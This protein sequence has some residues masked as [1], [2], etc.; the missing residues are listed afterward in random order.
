M[1]YDLY[2][3]QHH[4]NPGTLS[5]Y[6]VTNDFWRRSGLTAEQCLHY[7]T[8]LRVRGIICLGGMSRWSGRHLAEK[9][10]ESLWIASFRNRV[11]S[12]ILLLLPFTI[13]IL[14]VRWLFM[15]VFHLIHP[16][17]IAVLEEVGRIPQIGAIPPLITSFL[18]TI[19]SI[20]LLAFVL[21]LVGSI[22]RW[23]LIRRI[24]DTG[25]AII[26]K[27][28]MVRTIYSAI[29][30]GIQV[31][32]LPEGDSFKR[33]VL[34]EFPRRGFKALGFLTGEVADSNGK[35]FYTVFIPTSPNPT[36]GF[37]EIIPKEDVMEIDMTIEDAL[38][39]ILSGGLVSPT[40]FQFGP[41]PG[42]S[43]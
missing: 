34:I 6:F 39:M 17:V 18:V 2:I 38:S 35:P 31:L 7:N 12:G 37:F 15:I 32:S 23:I 16:L 20:V 14:V 8:S 19:L 29:Q 36:N 21:Y 43:E 11:M 24:V 5:L 1:I 40:G 28:P 30:Q 10:R 13:T 22:G 33:V 25:E 4:V 3:P 41:R 26:M 27:I 42:F 9:K